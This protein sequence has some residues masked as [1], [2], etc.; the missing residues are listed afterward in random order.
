MKYAVG[1]TVQNITPTGWASL[2]ALIAAIEA[3]GGS[4]SSVARG[5]IVVRD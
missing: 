5:G 2:L 4:H 1:A 3:A